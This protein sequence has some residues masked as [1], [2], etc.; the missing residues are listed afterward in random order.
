MQIVVRNISLY[1]NVSHKRNNDTCL[2]PK[3]INR[4]EKKIIY[5]V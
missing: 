5:P 3:K 2:V 1:I 4:N